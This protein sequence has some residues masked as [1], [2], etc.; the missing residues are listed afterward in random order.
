M[1]IPTE[2]QAVFVYGT[3]M[4]NQANFAVAG[5][6]Q[7]IYPAF[8]HGYTLW[9]LE[10]EGYPA[11]VSGNSTETVK[12]YVFFYETEEWNRILTQ[13]DLL[14]GIHEDPPLY[15]RIKTQALINHEQIEQEVWVYLYQRRR[16]LQEDGAFLIQSGNWLER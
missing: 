7:F 8:T 9:H 2:M 12:G 4:P 6:P 3:L 10:P 5:S 11:I 14:E 16:R 1:N 13:L 15:Q